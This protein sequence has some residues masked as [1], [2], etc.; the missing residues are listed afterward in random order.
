MTKSRMLNYRPM[1]MSDYTRS[2]LE[3]FKRPSAAERTSGMP[4]RAVRNAQRQIQRR[5]RA[6]ER[7]SVKYYR[8]MEPTPYLRE[9]LARFKDDADR[10]LVQPCAKN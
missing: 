6:F 8:P 4:R 2:L 5:R 7:A 1:E 3:R 9:I 10:N